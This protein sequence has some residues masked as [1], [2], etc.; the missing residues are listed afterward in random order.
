M[1]PA[2]DAQ[3]SLE[4]IALQFAVSSDEERVKITIVADGVQQALAERE[5]GYL[6][7]TLARAHRDDEHL[8][9]AERGWRHCDDLQRM[10]AIDANALNVAIHRARRQ[11]AAA[12]VFGAAGLVEVRRRQRRLGTSRFQIT[13]LERK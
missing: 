13:T 9:P 8:P 4:S 3:R 12:G 10:L 11:V 6:L 1:T 2:L 5:H 7:L